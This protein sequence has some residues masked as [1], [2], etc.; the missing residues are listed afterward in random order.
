MTATDEVKTWKG[1]GGEGNRLC[2]VLQKTSSLQSASAQD[3][4]PSAWD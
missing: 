1:G 4:P 2:K 3:A